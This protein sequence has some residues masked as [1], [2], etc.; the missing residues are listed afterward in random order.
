MQREQHESSEM[1]SAKFEHGN[2][3]HGN[4]GSLPNGTSGPSEIAQKN[5]SGKELQDMVL[6]GLQLLKELYTMIRSLN[7]ESKED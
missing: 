4:M 3:E 2:V 1:N 5:E 7:T 6:A